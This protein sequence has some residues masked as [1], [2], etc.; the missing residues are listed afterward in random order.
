MSQGRKLSQMIS[1]NKNPMPAG[2]KSSGNPFLT[3]LKKVFPARYN[4]QTIN[5]RIVNLL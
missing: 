5:S 1:Q 4:V 3:S 2:N